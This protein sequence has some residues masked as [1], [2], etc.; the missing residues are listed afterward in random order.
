MQ[1]IISSAKTC[2]YCGYQFQISA[3]D[4]DGDEYPFTEKEWASVCF[5][6]NVEH[7]DHEQEWFR[8]V[9][10]PYVEFAIPKSAPGTQ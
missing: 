10:T 7:Q 2:G 4:V 5:H 3:V 9:N 6:L 1:S 8:F